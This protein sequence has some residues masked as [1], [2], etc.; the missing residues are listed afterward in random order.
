MTVYRYEEMRST[1]RRR[2]T[3]KQCGT[4][5]N[6]QRTFTQTVNPF[7][8][9]D[10]GTVKTR[11]EVWRAVSAAAAAWQPDPLCGKCEALRQP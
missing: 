10:G 1:T 6:R 7:N 2:V 4:K 3:C 11:R 9:N 5:F 8:R